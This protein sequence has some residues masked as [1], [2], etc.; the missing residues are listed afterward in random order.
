MVLRFLSRFVRLILIGIIVLLVLFCA[1]FAILQT[2]W[3]KNQIRGKILSSLKESGIDATLEGLKGQPPFTWT[4]Q[5]ADLH[6]RDNQTLK[7]SNIKL[8]FAILPL[9]QGRVTINYLKADRADYSFLASQEKT[10][11]SIEKGKAFLKQKIEETHLPFPITLH[12]FAITQLNLVNREDH[13][14]ISLNVAGKIKLRQDMQDFA[15]ELTLFSP[16]QQRTYL[17]A[18]LNGNK[19]RNFIHTTIQ[20]HLDSIPS[21]LPLSCNVELGLNGPWTSWEEILYDKPLSAQPLSGD[22]K[23]VLKD[24]N[25]LRL[26]IPA[27]LNRPWTFKTH[28]FLSSSQHVNMQN[29]LLSSHLIHLKGKAEWNGTLELSKAILAFSMP[30][31]SLLPFPSCLKGSARGKAFFQEGSFKGSFQTHEL[32]CD[33]FFAHTTRGLIKG[34]MEGNEWEGELK[35]SSKDAKIPF[36]STVAFEYAPKSFLALNDVTLDIADGAMH[37]YLSYDIPDHLYSGSLFANVRHLDRFGFLFNE[38]NINGNLAAEC[39][40]SSLE[41]QQH[42]KCTILAKNMRYHEILLDDLT[43]SAEV[44]DIFSSPVG[45]LHLLAERVYTPQFYL[46]RL[47]FGT[48]SGDLN[49]SFFLDTEGRVESPFQCFAKG[50]WRKEN[51]LL[52]LELTQLSGN[53][54]T[55]PFSLKNPCELEWGAD[56]LNLSPF[57]LHIGQGRLYTTF[58]LSPIRSLG[59]WSLKHFPLKILGCIRPR[60]KLNGFIS[61]NGFF[62][63]TQHNIEGALNAVI[64]KAGVLH[65]GKK[66]PFRAKG[67]LQA[68]LN[69]H[70][71]QI[72]TDLRATDAQFLDFNASLPIDYTLYPFHITLDQTKNTSAELLAEG[73]LQDLFDFVNLGTN[74]FT[75]LVSCRLFLS[76]TLSHPSLLGQLEWQ[77]GSYENYFT[78]LSL[79]HV[80]ASFEA[81]NDVIDLVHLT[82]ADDK[83]GTLSMEGKILLKPKELFPYAF[84]A[85]LHNLHALG[86]DMIDC[87]LTGPLYLTGNIHNMFSQGNLLIDEATIQITERLPYE[88]PSLPVTYINRPSHLSSQAT[89]TG[90][91]FSFHLDLEVTANGNVLVKGRGLS[92]EL[93]GNVHLTGTDTDV[94]AKGALKLIKGD[95]QF[96]GKVFKLTEGEIV[97]NDKPTPSAY[98]NLNG[99]LSLPEAT[100]TAMLRGPLMSPQLTF[101]SNP[102]KSTSSILALILFNKDIADISP[103]E[104]IQLATTLVS[105]SGGA[106]PDVL[107]AIRK[108]IGIDRLNIASKPGSDEIAVQIGKYLTRGIMITLS[109]SATSSQVIVEVE[110]PRGFIFQAETQEEEEGKFSLKWRKS[111]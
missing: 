17:K 96:A 104:A 75:G 100:I 90:P 48:D 58:E 16:D 66:E 31:L 107:E 99:T 109:Q 53:L 39:I 73:T 37:G 77:N 26:N 32:Q 42:V 55:I 47:N 8:R 92:A 18:T 94:A 70:R 105:L 108:S 57:D 44:K 6:F 28:L 10:E 2:Q 56:Y 21:F 49:W 87:N 25:E 83:E 93:E 40:L 101:Q 29:L 20:A 67:S 97:F 13:S 27:I 9:L 88:T 103:P 12:H 74:H 45:H 46:D 54:S 4:I 82:A 35:L 85:E 81:K 63:A 102:Q 98:L 5:E 3:A 23:G 68:H 89:A 62:D 64:E 22:A 110:L 50:F 15:L 1:S 69:Q 11:F 84:N 7:L 111:Y 36:E 72:H 59:Q 95:Y 33:T 34:S 19:R 14:S 65:F 52:T 41:E 60:F 24:F 80:N 71:M 51:P 61:S 78:G 86:F 38:E 79:A 43:L 91:D 30:D 76:Q 106:G